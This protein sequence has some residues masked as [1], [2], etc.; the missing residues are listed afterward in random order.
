M[1]QKILVILISLLIVGALYL[2]TI[3][4]KEIVKVMYIEKIS[5]V[6]SKV[7]TKVEED[8]S[9]VLELK[10][11]NV[12]NDGTH[13]N[14]TTKGINDALKWAKDNGYHTFIVP[15]G[16]Y[17]IKKGEPYDRQSRINMVSDMTFIMEEGAVLE[18][19]ANGKER[20]ELMYIGPGIRNVT[21]KGGTYLG[22]KNGHDFSQKDDPYTPGTH[23][24][25]YGI[26]AE[27]VQNLTVD[28]I[29]A[30]NFTGDGLLVGGKATAIDG[31]N[32]A[33]FELGSIDENGNFITNQKKIRS[34]N[35]LKTH[36]NHPVF[37]QNR[38]LVLDRV[39]NLSL[40]H[41]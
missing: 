36:F 37:K 24:S 20:Y 17:L 40:I 14:E 31:L 1:N 12:Y 11:W 5:V 28:G 4:Q 29:V 23:E 13:P 35:K 39:Y 3:K 38:V 19:E 8:Y 26:F 2:V 33:D 10:K 6:E 41:I 32:E 15:K 16:K 34:K 18:K 21:L 22:D 9:Y 30:K 7:S 25:G 27:G